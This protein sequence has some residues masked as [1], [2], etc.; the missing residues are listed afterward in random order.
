MS[1]KHNVSC[2]YFIGQHYLYKVKLLQEM[3]D[4]NLTKD[5]TIKANLSN[6][7]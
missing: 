6:E 4:V 7:E 3:K 5:L 2:L 1:F